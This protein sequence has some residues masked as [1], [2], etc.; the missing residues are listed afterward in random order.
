MVAVGCVAGCSPSGP[1]PEVGKVG[2]EELVLVS[3]ALPFRGATVGQG[4][5]SLRPSCSRL[6]AHTLRNNSQPERLGAVEA[7]RAVK[8]HHKHRV[9]AVRSEVGCRVWHKQHSYLPVG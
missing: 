9:A 5:E 7:E 2:E 3:S 8:C 4:G 6:P 1:G